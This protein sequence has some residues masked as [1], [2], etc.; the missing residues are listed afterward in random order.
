[1]QLTLAGVVNGGQLACRLI[2]GCRNGC[3]FYM[4]LLS[5]RVVAADGQGSPDFQDDYHDA[6]DDV[7]PHRTDDCG[8]AQ[9]KGSED[10]PG[11]N[12]HIDP[13]Q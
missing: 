12:H 9:D 2:G 6:D 1:M 13:I 11:A 10:Q 7:V 4:G 3:L 8:V 5:N